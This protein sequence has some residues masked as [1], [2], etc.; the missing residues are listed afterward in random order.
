VTGRGDI[1]VSPPGR[2]AQRPADMVC[3]RDGNRTIIGRFCLPSMSRC[4]SSSG[5]GKWG[6]P[7]RLAGQPSG[8]KKNNQ[9]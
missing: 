2:K 5:S 9:L 7:E 8:T 4:V 1:W 6:S 3:G